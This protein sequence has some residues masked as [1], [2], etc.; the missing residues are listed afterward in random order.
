MS[1]QL[2]QQSP[3]SSSSLPA[4]RPSSA[5]LILQWGLFRGV[6][7]PP[8][9]TGLAMGVLWA[10]HSLRPSSSPGNK[11]TSGG[12]GVLCFPRAGGRSTAPG[13][14]RKVQ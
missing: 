8:V 7:G 12:L 10:L 1:P 4:G 5:K 6:I 13:V 2:V 3:G 11:E 9:G 14:L